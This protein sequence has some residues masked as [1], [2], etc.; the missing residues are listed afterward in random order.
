MSFLGQ[1]ARI[2]LSTMGNNRIRY[3]ENHSSQRF[4]W[5]SLL[6]AF[7]RQPMLKRPQIMP[8]FDNGSYNLKS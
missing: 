3:K 8:E 2:S 7:D 1:H 6:F 5:N 4:A